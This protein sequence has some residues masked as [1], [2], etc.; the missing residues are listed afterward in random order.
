MLT[1]N[2]A[3][4]SQWMGVALRVVD[5]NKTFAHEPPVA[6][7]PVTP[8]SPAAFV[9]SRLIPAVH[10]SKNPV[11]YVALS[12]PAA[13]KLAQAIHA[14][15]PQLDPVVLP[16]WDCLPYDRVPPSRQCMGRRMD[17]LRVW[18]KSSRDRKLMITSLDALLQRI[19]P[20]DAIERSRFQLAIGK[21][22]DRDAIE[23]FMGATGYVEDGVVDEP[24]EFAFRDEVVDIFP[25]GGLRPMRIVLDGTG[26]IAEL[27]A[28][29]PVTQ[30][31]E[32]TVETMVFGPASEALLAND[33]TG[34]DVRN[35]TVSEQHLFQLYGDLQTVFD[36]L[37]DTAIA[38]AP[39]LAE[40]LVSY[41]DI[42]DEAR[43]AHR[44]F[45]RTERQNSL[46]LD[47]HDWE[48]RVKAQASFSL[49]LADGDDAPTFSSAVNPRRALLNYVDEQM[50]A[51]RRVVLTGNDVRFESLCRRVGRERAEPIVT[52]DDWKEL[53]NSKPGA[54]LTVRSLLKHGFVDQAANLVVI[55]IDDI[56]GASQQAA[57]SAGALLSERELGLGDVVVH[58]DHGVGVLRG[59]ET[60][61][62]DDLVRDAARLDYHGGASILVPVEEFGKLWRYGSEQ[63]AVTLDRLHTDGWSKK[64]AAVEKDMR[65]TARHLLQLAKQRE[66]TGATV[67]VPPRSAYAKFVARFPY[68]LTVDQDSAIDAVLADLVSGVSMN[69][70]VCGDVGF[71]KTEIALRAAA[72]VALSGHQVIVVAP[73][74]VLARQHFSNFERRFAGTGIEV[75]MLSRLV[76]AEEAKRVKAGLESGEIAITI[77]T[78]AILAK[79][80]AFARLGLLIVDEEHRFGMRDKTA[81]HQMASPLHMLT[82]SATPIPRT[83]QSAMVGIQ[84]VSLLTTPPSRRRP[85]RTYLTDVDRGSMRVALIREHRRGGQ[86]FF[87]APRIEDLETLKALLGEV[88]PEL[89][90]RVAHGKIPV[91]EMD[92]VMV[93]FAEGDGDILLSTNII[94]SGLDVPRANTIFVWNAD[95][96]GLAQLH[97]LRGRVGRGKAQGVAYLLTSSEN[98]ISDDTRKRLETMVAHDRLGAG[99]A[100]SLQDL[101]QRGGGDLMGEEQA[102]HLKV[103]GISLYQKLLERA[104]AAARKQAVEASSDVSINLGIAGYIPMDYIPDAAVRL[105]VYGRVLRAAQSATVDAFDEEFADRFGE[106]PQEVTTLLRLTRLK[107]GATALG[108]AK[109]DGGPRG[110]AVTLH[111]KTPAKTVE[112]LMARHNAIRREE[113]IV[114][115]LCSDDVP[116]RLEFLEM[117]IGEATEST[118][119]S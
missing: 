18:S 101:D 102:G 27:R 40:R 109:I 113:R 11:V 111:Q 20:L 105:N 47:R 112:R 85:V 118:G 116:A 44:E 65:A 87:V 62:V 88:V 6:S 35:A 63:E 78:Q 61:T 43:E 70:L 30:R 10:R 19:P 54:L 33:D 26:N 66:T 13:A 41:L 58:E 5:Y 53:G 74:T 28:Y 93:G 60:V 57:A 24:G 50:E 34:T 17:A 83:L 107:I 76:S 84:D 39:G 48:K 38:F 2:S 115:E 67:I 86:S 4:A 64:R 73:T 29:D 46:Y 59:L 7:P 114:Y 71:G 31:T 119:S 80:V 15:D 89:D 69:R 25:A 77:A 79:D 3:E 104:V 36:V 51:G 96:F 14:L 110:I 32:Y 95:R 106:L 8:K 23:A 55:T 108:I 75:A 100:I 98:E 52:I 45:G 97:Q 81:M 68:F 21:P 56:L 22:F 16:P 92:S 91:D 49:D 12:E 72:A 37:S 9:A 103:I 42:I 99:L 90:L 117:L 94:E 1:T 82:M